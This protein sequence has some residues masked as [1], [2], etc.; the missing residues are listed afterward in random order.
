M[1]QGTASR[2]P[3]SARLLQDFLLGRGVND[4]DFIKIDVDGPDFLILRS[5]KSVLA[6][7]R[8]LGICIEVNFF[9]SDDPDAHT[10]HN[11]DRF[12]KSVG[13]ELFDLSKRHYS[14]AAL[15]A[16]YVYSVPPRASGGVSCRVT[17]YIFAIWRRLTTP[18]L[19]HR[20]SKQK[21]QNLPRFLRCLGFQIAQQSCSCDFD[22]NSPPFLTWTNALQHLC[23]KWP[24]R[25]ARTTLITLRN[26]KT[27]DGDFILGS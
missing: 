6:E 8:V 1:E 11:V 24:V 22:R 16:P 12:L 7:T 15:P 27:T 13:F 5:L 18:N 19:R 2:I 23:D 26:L 3:G 20:C 14:M 21:L 10:L 25:E 17:Q 9:G 4:V